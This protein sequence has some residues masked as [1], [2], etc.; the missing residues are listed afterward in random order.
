[1]LTHGY[2]LVYNAKTA[3]TDYIPS[4]IAI[5]EHQLGPNAKDL[6]F[7]SV[8]LPPHTITSISQSRW[9]SYDSTPSKTRDMIVGIK[10]GPLSYYVPYSELVALL[11]DEAC[12]PIT[13]AMIRS[14]GSGA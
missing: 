14:L 7:E 4:L 6:Y 11:D 9:V 8:E 12:D 13:A 3:P 2:R 1:M 5:D 10:A